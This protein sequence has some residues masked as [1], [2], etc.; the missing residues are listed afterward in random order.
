MKSCYALSI[1][2]DGANI[3]FVILHLFPFILCSKVHEVTIASCVLLTSSQCRIHRTEARLAVNALL[4]LSRNK[5]KM[6]FI[7]LFK[8][9]LFDHIRK[10][11]IFLQT[12]A[13]ATII[14]FKVIVLLRSVHIPS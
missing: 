5:K 6:T 7:Y 4:E 10:I 1:N 11:T 13:V 14:V 2:F 12:T 9:I 3:F 8:T